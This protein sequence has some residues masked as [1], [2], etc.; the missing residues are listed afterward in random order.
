MEL[1]FV[2]VFFML[3]YDVIWFMMMSALVADAG[4]K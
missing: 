4:W 2:I 3:Y 1:L